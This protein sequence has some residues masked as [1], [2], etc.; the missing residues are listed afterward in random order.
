MRLATFILEHEERILQEFEDFARTHTDAG[1]AMDIAAL[2]DHAS[3]ILRAIALD[4]GQPQTKAEQTEKS[5]GDA[6]AAPATK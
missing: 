6:P 5:M 2:R 1:E 3:A 4:I